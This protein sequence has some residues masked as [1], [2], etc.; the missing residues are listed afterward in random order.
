MY[1]TV[2]WRHR[3][4]KKIQQVKSNN[5]VAQVVVTSAGGCLLLSYIVYLFSGEF[6]ESFCVS[7]FL[8]TLYFAFTVNRNIGKNLFHPY[9]YFLLVG[10][11]LTFGLPMVLIAANPRSP[12]SAIMHTEHLAMVSLLITASFFMYLIGYKL[13]LGAYPC[14]V[15]SPIWFL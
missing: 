8:G 5:H 10:G 1:W 2:S 12:A 13:P 7:L 14:S 11:F 9:S 4:H 15:N 3:N 6:F